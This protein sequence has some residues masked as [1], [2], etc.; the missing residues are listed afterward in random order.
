MNA[1]GF[2]C[3]S[4]QFA[5]HAISNCSNYMRKAVIKGML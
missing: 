2:R 3:I 4:G 5:L 1:A